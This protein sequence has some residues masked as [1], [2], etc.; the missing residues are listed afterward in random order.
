MNTSQADGGQKLQ[1]AILTFF[2]TAGGF[3]LMTLVLK[4]YLIPSWGQ[5][6][7]GATAAYGRL[8]DRLLTPES[9]ILQQQWHASEQSPKSQRGLRD[10]ITE[11]LESYALSYKTFPPLVTPPSRSQTGR[12]EVQ[13]SLDLN[14]AK[15]TPI[16]QFVAA[17][18]AAKSTVRVQSFDLRRDRRS[19][20]EDQWLCS[21]QF[22]DY[23]A[24]GGP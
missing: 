20:G 18:K 4:S 1:I 9:K 17:V 2:M 19:P 5:A 14:V 11:K 13:Q 24:P 21:V 23:E 10:L 3:F 6:A 15:M 8:G 16:L 12:R 7:T 22:V